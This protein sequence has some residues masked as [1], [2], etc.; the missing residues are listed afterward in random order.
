[1]EVISIERGRGGK[2]FVNAGLRTLPHS[3]TQK[4]WA[5]QAAPKGP[6]YHHKAQTTQAQSTFILLDYQIPENK[7]IQNS[8]GKKMFK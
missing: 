1:M 7:S 2:R 4:A 6:N 8:N 3:R 5:D